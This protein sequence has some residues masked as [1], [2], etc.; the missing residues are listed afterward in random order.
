MKRTES[1][2]SNGKSSASSSHKKYPYLAV[3][4]DNRGSEASLQVGKIYQIVKPDPHDGSLDVRVI[5]EEGEDYLY[6]RDQFVAVD[7]PPKARRRLL[8]A[9]ST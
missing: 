6:A 7:L 4:I 8:S 3:C 1:E 9:V 5:D 2:K